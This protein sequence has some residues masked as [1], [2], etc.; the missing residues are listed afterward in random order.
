MKSLEH[1]FN[2]KFITDLYAFEQMLTCVKSLHSRSLT[3]TA[4]EGIYK[5]AKWIRYMARRFDIR[6]KAAVCA[7]TY[8]VVHRNIDFLSLLCVYYKVKNGKN[9]WKKLKF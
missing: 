3:L 4:M 1:S 8:H 7:E 9:R 6:D 2:Y 5:S